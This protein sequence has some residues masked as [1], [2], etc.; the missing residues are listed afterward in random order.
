M[1]N[2]DLSYTVIVDADTTKFIKQVTEAKNKVDKELSTIDLKTLGENEEGKDFLSDAKEAMGY[3][4]A[5]R[6]TTD[7]ISK[8]DSG[9][10]PLYKQFAVNILLSAVSALS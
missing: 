4:D 7:Q 2:N 9:L 5:S 10:Q 1:N 8:L 3:I 6:F